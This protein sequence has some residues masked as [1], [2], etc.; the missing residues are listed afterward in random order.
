MYEEEL[1]RLKEEYNKLAVR[2]NANRERLENE[3]TTVIGLSVP[4]EDAKRYTDKL[5]RVS[6]YPIVTAIGGRDDTPL[7]WAEGV[8]KVV[9]LIESVEHNIKLIAKSAP[10]KV[11][12]KRAPRG[13]RVFIVHGHDHEMLRDVEAYVRRIDIDPV[14]L[15]DEPNKGGTVVEKFERNSAVQFAIVLFSPDD[16]GR[17]FD[18]PPEAL[19]RRPRQNA[20]LELGFFIGKLGRENTVLLVD[21]TS[22][23]EVEYPSDLGGLIPISYR[24]DSD[25]KTK[26]TREFRAASIPY[27]KDK[28]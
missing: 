3:L 25:W 24:R 8:R 20:V 1:A 13:N 10:G 7:A 27:N 14:I 11:A 26:L 22:T 19:K 9:G 23:D 15:I 2:D 21:A 16:M 6:F 4:R 28:A 12:A 17:A 18:A 5:R